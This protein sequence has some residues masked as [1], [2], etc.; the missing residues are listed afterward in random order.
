M[1]IWTPY[2]WRDDEY[3]PCAPQWCGFRDCSCY[4]EMSY[5]YFFH[6]VAIAGAL[7]AQYRKGFG[8]GWD[9][10]YWDGPIVPKAPVHNPEDYLQVVY[11]KDSKPR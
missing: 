5:G 3:G 8:D 11:T 6:A 2:T 1:R 9:V 10:A 4:E 7:K